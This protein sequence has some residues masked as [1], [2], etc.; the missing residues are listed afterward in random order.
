MSPGVYIYTVNDA[1]GS[2]KRCGTDTVEIM[3][4]I[5]I[6]RIACRHTFADGCFFLFARLLRAA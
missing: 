6:L 5:E 3:R 2:G 4:E 1:V